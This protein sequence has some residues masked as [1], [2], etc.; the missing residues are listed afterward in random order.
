MTKSLKRLLTGKELVDRIVEYAK[1]KLAERITLIDLSGLP[2]SADWFIIC[3]SD[4]TTQN[5][6]VCD[7]IDSRLSESGTRPWHCEGEIEGRWI[8]M[9]YSDVVVHILLPDLRDYYSLETIWDKARRTDI[10]W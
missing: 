5:R 10:D 8:L 2:G 3:Q 4:N 1:D 7:E 9:D 6:A